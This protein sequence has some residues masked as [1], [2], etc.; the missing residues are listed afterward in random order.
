MSSSR[1]LN[2]EGDVKSGAD[3]S[4]AGIGSG[5]EMRGGG[6]GFGSGFGLG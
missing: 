3:D 1:E 2:R 5:G 6:V 4:N